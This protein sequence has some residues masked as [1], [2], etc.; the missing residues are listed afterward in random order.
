MPATSPQT[1]RI[2][3]IILQELAAHEMRLLTLIVAVRKAV[4]A[5]TAVKGDLS[6]LV[7]S[8]VQRLVTAKV[9]VDQDGV[10]SLPKTN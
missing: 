8:S 6:A 9:V 4:T 5:S 1:T 3:Q 7:Q 2:E 10:F